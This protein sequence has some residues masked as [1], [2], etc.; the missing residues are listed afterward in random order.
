MCGGGKTKTSTSSTTALPQ[1]ANAYSQLLGQAQDVASTPWNPATGQQV[2]GFSNPQSQAFGLTQQNLGAYQPALSAA[3]NNAAYG[4]APIS[5]SAIQNY[6]DPYTQNVVDATQAQFAHQNAQQLQDVNA[7]AAKIGALTGDRSQVAR[8]ITQN[9]Q[10]L[11]QNPIIAGLYSQGYSQAL[12]AAQGDA[13]RALQGAQIQGN[14]AGAA[15]QYGANDVNN[16][17]GIGGLQQQYQQNV[18]NAGTANAQSQAQ[19]PFAT[20]QWLASLATGLGGAAGT[21]SSQ[22]QPGPNMWSQLAGLG[23]GAASLF[24]RGGRVGYDSGGTVLPYGGASTYVPTAGAMHGGMNHQGPMPSID[25]QTGGGME[26]VLSN[27]KQ[28]KS[29]FQGLGN[30]GTK[31]WNYANTTTDPNSGWATTVTPS[32]MSGIGNYLGSMFG[33]AEGGTVR[34][35]YEDGGDVTDLFDDGTGTFSPNGG[36]M[37]AGVGLRTAVNDDVPFGAWDQPS[38]I[39]TE[40]SPWAASVAAAPSLP[41]PMHLGAPAPAEAA[42]ARSEPVATSY[43]LPESKGLF[44]LQLSDPVRQGLLAAGLGMLASDSPFVGTAIGQGGLQ[45]LKAYGNSKQQ[46]IENTQSKQRIDMEAQRLAQAAKE[47]SERMRIASL[48][49]SRAA[50]AFPLDQ[51][52]KELSLKLAQ[53]PKWEAIGTDEFGRTKYAFVNP[54]SQTV[55]G[56]PGTPATAAGA[57]NASLGPNGEALGGD[58][59]L[60]TLPLNEATMVKK[61]VN[62]EIPPPS[63]YVLAKS[64]YWN[65]LMLKAAQYDPDFD[66]TSWAARSAGRK[67]FYGGGK[68]AEMVRAANQTIDHVGHL[69]ESFDKLGNTQYPF[70][71]SGKNYINKEITGKSGV[72]D[73]LANAHAV[74]DEMSKVFKGSNLSDT[75][76]K[77]WEHSLSANMSPEQQR[78]AVAKLMDLLG[79][80]LNALEQKRQSS[81]G[82]MLSKKMGALLNDHSQDV[83]TRVKKW[84]DGGEFEHAPD[85]TQGRLGD[86]PPPE[87]IQLLKANPDAVHRASFDKH[88][89]VGAADKIL[90]AR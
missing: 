58:D 77:A 53:A 13:N 72:P 74:A 21:N 52:T 30:L 83:L 23:L 9:Q 57:E 29:A 20:T 15:Q 71:N 51:Q 8:S 82:P 42:V 25:Q 17:L 60:K 12:G 81:L 65:A 69:V 59:Y 3:N 45:G 28:A 6:M 36:L 46:T 16:L 79:G 50:Q 89:G 27:F 55:A 86:G 7:N 14:L 40:D 76:I 11:A 62:G 48:E 34:K 66:Q 90:G 68:S 64:P 1:Y 38:P 39:G 22:T 61:M 63:S 43:S 32:G 26:D 78:A 44:G 85:K 18:L 4:S 31:A 19:Y 5:A 73:F 10:S 56:A 87:A 80:S 24:N 70:I 49:E 54:L 33:F 84:T 88:F 2:A 35:G 41:E 75:E 37:N 67:D 47:A